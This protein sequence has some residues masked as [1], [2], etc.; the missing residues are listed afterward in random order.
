[1]AKSNEVPWHHVTP[2]E[3]LARL[4]SAP[5]GISEEEAERRLRERGPNVLP[6]KGRRSL[7]GIFLSQF[8][9]PLIYLLFAAAAIAI[10]L[11][12][13][14][15]AGVI[16]G[17]VL[18]NAAIGA[19]QEGRAERSMT[20]L[21]R[22]AAA[23]ARVL[24]GG[25][26]QS[27]EARALVPGDVLLLAA[28]DAVGADARL[29]SAARLQML[30]AS[31]TG[32]SQP[33]DKE[34]SPLPVDATLADRAS[35]VYAGTHVA[36]GRGAA[37]VV[38]TGISTEIGRIALLAESGPDAQTPLERRVAQL[39]RY[40][41]FIA[42]AVFALV[43]GVGFLRGLP[44]SQILLVAISQLVS[45]VPEGLPVAMTIGLAVGMQRMAAR[46]AIVRRLAAVESL[47]STT[48][49]C[50]DKTGTLTRNEMTV[51]AVV[52]PGAR[53]L[54]VTGVGYA[55]AGM[56]L[57]G[58]SAVRAEVDPDLRQ[59]AHAGA[60]CNDA[61]IAAPA[62]HGEPWRA[63]GDPTEAALLPLAHKAGVD[64]AG[65]RARWPRLREIPFSAEHKMMATEHGGPSGSHVFLK[66]APERILEL[67]A[68]SHRGE[69]PVVLE[70]DERRALEAAAERMGEAA[71]RVLAFA[72]VPGGELDATS[73][74]ADLRGRAVFLGMVGEM[75]PPR[76]EAARA[77]EQCRSAGIRPV[78]IT[79]DHKATGLAVARTLDIA[80]AD[81]IALDG[82]E[83]AA[84]SDDELRR[85][86][87]RISVYARVH[88][89]QKLRIVR[90]LQ[91]AG[92]VVAMTGDGVNDA[93]AL[94]RADIGVA[95]G[96]TGTEV[97]KEASEI[98]ITDD[99]FATIVG[100]VEE[101]RVV[102]GNV[103]KALLLLLSTGLAEVAVL[104]I[105]VVVGL[106]L[107]FAAVQILWN[108]VVTEGTITVNLAMEPGEGDEMG[109]PPISRHEA[110][111]SRPL[112]TRMLL[113]S[114]AIAVSTLGFFAV[115]LAQG[116]PFDQAR[117]GTFTL[118]AVCEWF[119]VLNCRSGTQSALRMSLL[120]NPWLLGGLLV[121]NLLQLAVVY[122]APL[123][124]VFH[125]VPLSF[126]EFLAIGVAGS[127]VLWAEELR[128][129]WVRRR[130]RSA[131]R[132][133]RAEP[134]AARV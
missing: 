70:E 114:G 49:I 16:L 51:T 132:I 8:K 98:V 118:L 3:A 34:L 104:V 110:M 115:R 28:G 46:R 60:L 59:L 95:M 125:T 99:N 58:E 37:V 133:T 47:G 14:A 128:K 100:A 40:L 72:E 68:T 130:A 24:R 119:N 82:K 54:T 127:L 96:R 50:T 116:V 1:M 48:V 27:V 15:D 94:A 131:S 129:L 71:L 69:R 35:M 91:D 85:R 103:K 19:F 45:T 9:S 90:A 38:A 7:L 111:L 67:C 126:A 10:A 83:L 108:N 93:P 21:R 65:A 86:L 123:Q 73:S 56:L 101:G 74:F 75:D 25:E 43:V 117:T 29:L 113:M 12:E 89:E 52:L 2:E 81:E 39:G 61:E 92:N 42:L 88:P 134:A 121:S 120:R 30:E 44:P 31:L 20:A 97:A 109:R 33:S 13:R 22:M 80:R 122:F 124:R 76:E 87:P 84:L 18:V 11:D 102:Y 112:V 32:E 23:R 26:E 105:A 78:M 63:I 36:S 107:P 53:E 6:E 62:K 4:G 17:V 57:E 41:L 79:G 55:P 5:G 106:P 66:G 77:V 64:A